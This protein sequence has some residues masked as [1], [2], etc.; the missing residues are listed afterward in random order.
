MRTMMSS[1][2]SAYRPAAIAVRIFAGIGGFVL[3]SD[4]YGCATLQ[5]PEDA[6]ITA[7]VETQLHQQAD[8]GPPNLLDVQTVDHVVYLSGSVSSGLQREAAEEVAQQA[9]G[10]AR[11][12]DSIS[13]TH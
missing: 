3:L 11:I 10:G 13:V 2:R 9:G 5:S 12:V 7:N 8:L 6:K 4:L 1:E